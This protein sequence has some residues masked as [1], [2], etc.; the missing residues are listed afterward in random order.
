MKLFYFGFTDE[1]RNEKI[2]EIKQSLEES[3]DDMEKG[4][5]N[6]IDEFSKE[7]EQDIL[8]SCESEE[9]KQYILLERDFKEKT[10]EFRNLYTKKILEIN[11]NKSME[12][13]EKSIK[14]N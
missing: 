2:D 8:D 4:H 10:K 7:L 13:I 5:C 1:Y 12:M 9:E 6:S 14:S 3:I 11:Y